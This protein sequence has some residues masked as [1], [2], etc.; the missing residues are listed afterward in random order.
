MGYSYLDLEEGL[1]TSS[2]LPKVKKIIIHRDSFDSELFQNIQENLKRYSFYDDTLI[3]VTQDYK[4]VLSEYQKKTQYVHEAKDTLLIYP[5]KGRF[6]H[7]CPGSDGMVCCHYFVINFGVNCSFDCSYCYL[8]TYL[9]TP[10]LTLFSNVDDLLKQVQE[11]VERNPSFSWR[12][13]TGEYTDSLALDH[14]TK[15][16]SKLIPFFSELNGVTLELKTKSSN[17]SEILQQKP[18]E[19]IVISWS[20]SPDFIAREVERLTA[21]TQERLEAAA[22]LAKKG[23]HIGFHIDPIIYYDDW[24]ADYKQLIQDIFE[25]VPANSIRWISMGTFRYSPGLKQIIRTRYP[26]EILTRSEMFPSEDGKM[27]YFAPQRA[28]MYKTIKNW[29]QEKDEN[30]FTY[31]CMENKAMWERVYNFV[32]ENPKKLEEGFKKRKEFISSLP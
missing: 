12:I 11:K 1:V 24:K 6:F 8:Q 21:P 32:P 9:N 7:S 31:L 16:S 20:L 23:F 27:R 15:L 5:H 22:S 14:L 28:T 4:A 26:N 10:L 3:E 19:N 13:G 18:S 30:L 2:Y 25:R 29:I 17:I